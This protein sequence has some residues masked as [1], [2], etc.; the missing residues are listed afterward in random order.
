MRARQGEV[1]LSAFRK[2]L[3][4]GLIWLLMVQ[5]SRSAQAEAIGQQAPS[6]TAAG[7]PSPEEC[8]EIL[9]G[10]PSAA[11][12]CAPALVPHRSTD[13]K[14]AAQQHESDLEGPHSFLPLVDETPISCATCAKAW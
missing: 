11:V 1:E 3:S 12:P 5:T 8:E 2:V 13:R 9:K 6:S 4:W 14:E 7:N 10:T